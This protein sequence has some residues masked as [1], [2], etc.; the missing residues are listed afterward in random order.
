[1]HVMRQLPLPPPVL[2]GA[3][4][5][6]PERETLSVMR[7]LSQRGSRRS[8]AAMFG[9]HTPSRQFVPLKQKKLSMVFPGECPS[10]PKPSFM[11]PPLNLALIHE[12]P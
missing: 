9:P 3:V 7:Q 6:P 4:P 1:M 8:L 2:A 5:E 12:P 10:S 11:S